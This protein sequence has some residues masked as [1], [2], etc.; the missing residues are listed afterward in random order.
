M[1]FVD[2]PSPFW[3]L[4][5]NLEVLFRPKFTSPFLAR[6]QIFRGGFTV[7]KRI[8]SKSFGRYDS[9][10]STR[11]WAQLMRSQYIGPSLFLFNIFGQKKTG[12]QLTPNQKYLNIPQI[13]TFPPHQLF[14]TWSNLFDVPPNLFGWPPDNIFDPMIK[15]I[16][17]PWLKFDPRPNFCPS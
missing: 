2:L 3:H 4:F 17:N 15:S 7:D 1:Q 8:N 12:Q 10:G 14:T 6:C 13:I 9:P 11:F 5:V 16:L